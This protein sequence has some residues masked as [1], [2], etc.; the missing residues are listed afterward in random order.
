MTGP[1]HERP[2]ARARQL[3][4]ETRVR[5]VT[6]LKRYLHTKHGEGLLSAASVQARR[7]RQAGRPWRSAVTRL[8][9][10]PTWGGRS[11]FAL[12]ARTLR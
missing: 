4:I 12:I 7:P 8:P 6:G 1:G 10:D 2:C 3:L 5:L 11:S 9:R